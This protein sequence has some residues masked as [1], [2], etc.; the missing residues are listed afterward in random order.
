MANEID[1]NVSAQL[2]NGSLAADFKP[3]N[4]DITQT[5]ALVDKKTVTVTSTAQ[6]SVAFTGVTTYGLC[7][8]R[9]LDTVD[10]MDWGPSTTGGTTGVMI[11]RIKAGEVAAFRL[12][13][14]I[15]MR[16]IAS[17]TAGGVQAQFEVWND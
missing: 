11:G 12:K 14:G 13:P 4:L 10:Y 17:S 8:I 5:A 15:G 16:A 2:R 3:G 1:F 9:N 6:V 7:F